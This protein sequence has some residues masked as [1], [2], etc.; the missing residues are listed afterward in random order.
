MKAIYREGIRKLY[1][2]IKATI[3]AKH[4]SVFLR[5][6]TKHKN[7]IRDIVNQSAVSSV[8]LDNKICKELEGLGYIEKH[9]NDFHRYCLTA[10]G[11]WHYELSRGNLNIES[12][13]RVIN[14]IYFRS[15]TDPI[16]DTGKIILASLLFNR[17]LSNECSIKLDEDSIN[18]NYNIAWHKATVFTREILIKADIIADSKHTFISSNDKTYLMKRN[19]Y[20]VEQTNGI[21]QRHQKNRQH[22]LDIADVQ[23]IINSRKLKA[24]FKLL[25]TENFQD[26][27]QIQI[28]KKALKTCARNGRHLLSNDRSFLDAETTK[29]IVAIFDN[30][31]L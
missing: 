13:L 4:S 21:Y 8:V 14:T 20:L 31:Y 27:E 19:N 11:L 1:K 28:I 17:I 29:K 30:E 3:G 12:L 7:Q 5:L 16:D 25:I 22:Y 18:S 26:G 6:F 15:T 9:P 10:S 23:G 2:P 24:I